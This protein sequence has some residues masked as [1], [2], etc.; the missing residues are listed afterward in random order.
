MKDFKKISAFSLNELIKN[1]GQGHFKRFNSRI[2]RLV[3]KQLIPERIENKEDKKK[4][5]IFFSYK[6]KQ[7]E[8]LS[9][10]QSEKRVKLY[11]KNL[12]Q[13]TNVHAD[14]IFKFLIR[15]LISNNEK[16]LFVSDDLL[17]KQEIGLMLTNG[18]E[19]F[20]ITQYF[21]REF[22]NGEI[23]KKTYK[24]KVLFHIEGESHN[25]CTLIKNKRFIREISK[26]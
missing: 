5:D 13:K 6:I 25:L 8:G 16:V 17:C 3:D 4:R 11:K 1:K 12:K 9:K 26:N 15:D 2:T 7:E 14:N 21:F 23:N 10:T 19:N 18:D 24:H 22:K 20:D